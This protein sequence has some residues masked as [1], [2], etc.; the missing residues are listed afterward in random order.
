MA[1][2]GRPR[3]EAARERIVRAATELFVRDGYVATTIGAIAEQ[4]Q[5]AVKTIYAAYGNK[6]GVLSA[7]HD[8]RCPGRG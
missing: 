2:K 4:A 8:P 3:D 7:A 5:V 6:L 1:A